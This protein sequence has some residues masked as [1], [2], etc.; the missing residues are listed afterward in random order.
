VNNQI[1]LIL[2]LKDELEQLRQLNDALEATN[3]KW[4]KKLHDMQRRCELCK[5][6]KQS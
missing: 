2:E 1:A 3:E 4:A 5:S 6:D